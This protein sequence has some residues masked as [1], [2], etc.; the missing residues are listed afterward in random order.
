MITLR[1]PEPSDHD[2]LIALRD[3]Q[4]HRFMG[5]GSPDPWPTF[6]IVVDDAVVGWVDAEHEA[7]QHWLEPHEA[8]L[9][10]ALHPEH[11]GRGYATRGVMLLLHHLAHTGQWSVATLAIDLGN[12]WSVGVARRCGFVEHGTITG[13]KES[14]FFRRPVPPLT[15]TDGVVTIRKPTEADAEPSIV[16]TDEEQVRWLFQPEHRMLWAA[17]TPME[18]LEHQR[19]HYRRVGAAFGAGPLWFFTIEAAGAYSG[20]VEANL[21]NPDVPHGEANVSYTCTPALRGRGHATAAVRLVVDFLRDHTGAREAHIVVSAGNEASLR[22][23]RAVGAV[24][25]ERYVDDA[26]STMVRHVMTITR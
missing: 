1:P 12:D 18:K 15:Y 14:H 8:N 2:A 13:E 3:E 11:R 23:A 16:A 19:A 7:S 17:K 20:H 9:G 21:A 10:Y 4:F 25:T 6:C 24:E 26:G 5:E 22:V